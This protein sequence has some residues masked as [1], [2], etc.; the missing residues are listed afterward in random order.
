MG[1]VRPRRR[2]RC[3]RGEN[4]KRGRTRSRGRVHSFSPFRSPLGTTSVLTLFL[5]SLFV[6]STVRCR[7]HRSHHT[8][9]EDCGPRPPPRVRFALRARRPGPCCCRRGEVEDAVIQVVHDDAGGR[10]A[11]STCLGSRAS[12]S[13]QVETIRS[14]PLASH[15]APPVTQHASYETIL[16]RYVRPH[17]HL[18]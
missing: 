6:L 14:P 13:L 5:L 3:R 11:S 15:P 8:H 17:R 12:P 10:A 9:I 16:E 18:M 2:D 1:K 4:L 7:L